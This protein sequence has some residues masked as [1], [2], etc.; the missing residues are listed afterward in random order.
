MSTIGST[1]SGKDHIEVK[2]L[3][4]KNEAKSVK[5][6]E[7]LV[8]IYTCGKHIKVEIINDKLVAERKLSVVMQ[9][10]KSS[11]ARK[12][13]GKILLEGERLIRDAVEAGA[14]AEM[15]FFS[16]TDLLKSIPM[17]SKQPELYQV[18]HNAIQLWSEMTTSP[19]IIGIFKIPQPHLAA[20]PNSFPI[21]LVCDN[22]RDP[23]NMGTV[24]RCAAAVGCKEVIAMKGCVDVW[25]S[26]VIRSAAGAHFRVSLS[27]NVE[28]DEV[29]NYLSKD[30]FV[31][32]ADSS[33]T[34]TSSVDEQLM[35][36]LLEAE[37]S[38][39]SAVEVESDA[40]GLVKKR[41]STF[42]NKKLLDLYSRL[43]LPS[44][45]YTDVKLEASQP[46]FLIVGG[47]AHGISAA[48]RKLAHE[49]GGLKVHIPLQN[50]V[51]SLNV[52]VA[53]GILS[54]EIRRQ[55]LSC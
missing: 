6:K 50:G 13:S 12:A 22:L 5:N 9:M 54:F 14:E 3:N 4:V 25:D 17:T 35:L 37:K 51:E 18:N 41:D 44:S 15:I 32:L 52:G 28:W 46:V 43:P 53:F 45:S 29:P 8:P 26:K 19:G 48:A 21:T 27:C 23:G 49:F 16:N 47:E 11:K 24:L 34:E 31:I 30:A 10:V 55:L 39:S 42:R 7:Q 40:D 36:A 20:P 2:K 38:S 33:P 1:R